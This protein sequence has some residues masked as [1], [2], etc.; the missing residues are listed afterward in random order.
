MRLQD[1]LT[2]LGHQLAGPESLFH[3]L[4]QPG[5]FDEAPTQKRTLFKNTVNY[6]EFE[7]HAFCNRLCHFCPNS[8]I[9]R[10]SNK[11]V[12]SPDVH[13]KVLADLREIDYA[14]TVAYARYSEPMA[15][16]EIF[17]L[18]EDA[19][20]HLPAAYLKII[21]NGDYLTREKVERLRAAGLDFLAVSIYLP[22]STPWS[23]E[24]AT[25]EIRTLANRVKIDCQITKITETSIFA[26]FDIDGLKMNARCHDFGLGKQGFD[27]GK[28]VDWMIDPG[29]VRNDPCS[30]VFRNFTMGYNG[31]VMPCC[32]LRSDV[33]E[34][35]SFVLGNVAEANIF[36]IYAG[37]KFIEWRRGLAD[38]SDKQGPCRLC[39]DARLSTWTDRLALAV[40]DKIAR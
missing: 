1:W 25:E 15:R 30:F 40:W 29:F 36:D 35:A 10:R 27:R 39:K 21:S 6:V 16:E 9:D 7:P 33:P 13:A 5:I 34:Q 22:A 37:P 38:F 17:S 19:R 24:S 31:A 26:D 12:L 2:S 8:S 4:V 11:Q 23:R 20:R 32:N 18:I 3:C 28:A 14:G